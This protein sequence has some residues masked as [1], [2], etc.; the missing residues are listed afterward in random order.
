MNVNHLDIV[1]RVAAQHAPGHSVESTLGF[2][3]AVL[4]AL[5][6]G[7]RAGLLRKDAGENIFQ[8]RGVSVS[9]GR[10]CYPDGQLYKIAT[11]IPSTNAP[12]WNDDG[13]VDPARY[14]AVVS[15][16]PAPPPSVETPP[17]V[18]D[19]SALVDAVGHSAAAVVAANDRLAHALDVLGAKLDA[20]VKSGIRVHV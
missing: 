1:Q 13:T 18:V 10:V 20:V 17:T 12:A 3:L 5:P 16:A 14:V 6:P 11:D 19:L 4:A 2:T 9:V 8:Y 7:E 15:D